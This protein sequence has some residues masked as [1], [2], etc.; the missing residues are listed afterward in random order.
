[1]KSVILKNTIG[2]CIMEN[3]KV[4]CSETNTHIESSYKIRKTR[5]M[6]RF[7]VSV[8]RG[9]SHDMAVWNR[10]IRS[11]IIEWQAHNIAYMLHFF[12]KRAKDLDLEFPKKRLQWAC[13]CVASWFYP[14]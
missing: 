6:M 1:M 2:S 9:V 12:R 5:D 11:Q 14:F 3:L 13:F 4:T 10:S 8:R 7:L